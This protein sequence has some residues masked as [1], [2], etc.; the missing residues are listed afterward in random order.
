MPDE[1]SNSSRRGKDLAR[2][3]V[4]ESL[5]GVLFNGLVF[6]YLIWVVNLSPPATL[7]GSNGVVASFTKATGFA[8]SLMTII[9]TLLWRKNAANGAI[10]FV[11][12]AV[13]A[14][15][16]LTPRNIVGRTLFFVFLALATLMPIGVAACFCFGLYPMT[17][18]SFAAINVCYGTLVGAVVTP[19]VT[20]AAMA[21]SQTEPGEGTKH[22][23]P[24]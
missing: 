19:W 8:V 21:E 13:L 18:L 6:P 15:S 3:L 22:A 1:V 23:G 5:V 4:R 17:K 10:P 12:A 11:G 24:H 2:V 20:L 9:L 7:G 14:W 16:R